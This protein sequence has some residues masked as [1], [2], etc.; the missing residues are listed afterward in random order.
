MDSHI[1]RASVLVEGIYK[2]SYKQELI[3]SEWT[4]QKCALEN[5]TPPLCKAS[6]KS[7][8]DK[9]RVFAICYIG[10]AARPP[11]HSPC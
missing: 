11:L 6:R 2:P 9:N 8:E 10:T 1:R 7:F 4:E 5:A 3:G